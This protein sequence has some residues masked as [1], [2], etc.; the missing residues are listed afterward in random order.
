MLNRFLLLTSRKRCRRTR[1][2]L[3][4][5]R[6]AGILLLIC[7]V[8]SLYTKNGAMQLRVDVPAR[9]RQ[10]LIELFA[11]TGG[12]RWTDHDGWGTA[13]PT[14]DWYGVWCTFLGGETNRPVVAGIH[15]A[16]NNLRGVLPASVS[17]LWHLQSLDVAGNHLTG[18]MPETLLRRWDRHAFEFNGSGNAFSNFVVH[19]VLEYSASGTLCAPDADVRYR[20]EVDGVTG[21]AV[22]QTIRCASS[23]VRS[24]ETYCLVRTGTL[25]SLERFSRALAGLGFGTFQ[26]NYDFPFTAQTHGLFITTSALWG[27]GSRKAVETYARQGPR[28]VWLAQ[29]LFLGLLSEADWN[30][31]S[32]AAKCSFER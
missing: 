5:R 18:V 15:L 32:R 14:C 25:S 6:T 23:D 24:R 1:F 31:E 29:Q 27:N 3:V 2:K 12:D 17:I 22:F 10:V 4:V 20:F 30:G 19:V 16:A 8:F 26:S 11:A 21:R 7:F 13:R 9:E 28:D